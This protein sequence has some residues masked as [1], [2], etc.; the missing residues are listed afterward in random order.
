MKHSKFTQETRNCI[1]SA[2]RDG[3]PPDRAAAEAGVT[4]TAVVRWLRRGYFLDSCGVPAHES[5]YVAFMLDFEE[6]DAARLA[7]LQG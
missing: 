2:L 1:L 4:W 5:D 7:R 6:A 3:Q